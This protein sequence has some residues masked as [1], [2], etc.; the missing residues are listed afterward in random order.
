M[1]EENR[2]S[3]TFWMDF[4]IADRFGVDAITDTYKRAFK[5]WKHDYLMFTE[6]VMTL[7]HKCWSYY[8][9]NEKY[10][11]LYRELFY[12]ADSYVMSHYKGEALK[13]YLAVTD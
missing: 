12:D 4:D 9:V 3:H 10:C 11:E 7:N 5:G 2:P 6:L 1:Y 13:H 8:E